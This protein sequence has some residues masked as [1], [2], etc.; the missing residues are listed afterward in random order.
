MHA[1]LLISF[2]GSARQ[3]FRVR[4]GGRPF[5]EVRTEYR[6]AETL[7]TRMAVTC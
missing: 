3:P 7:A 2:N 5:Q 4:R 1:D 6:L